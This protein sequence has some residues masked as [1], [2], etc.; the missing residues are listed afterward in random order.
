MQILEVYG[1]PTKHAEKYKNLT[2]SLWAK[3][4]KQRGLCF[5]LQME[6]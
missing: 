2:E 1:E 6:Q 3:L 4:Q 5:H